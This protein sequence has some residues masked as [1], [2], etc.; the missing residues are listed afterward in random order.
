ML[1][2]KKNLQFTN[3][4]LMNLDSVL[5]NFD[6]R[7]VLDRPELR[8]EITPEAVLD[9]LIA[10]NQQF[11]EIHSKQIQ[12]NNSVRLSGAAKGHTPFAAVLNYARLSTSIEDVFDRKFGELY[13]INSPGQTITRP[14]ISAIE[15]GIL[16]M[17]IKVILILDNAPKRDRQPDPV[18][19]RQHFK[20][21]IE[22]NKILVSKSAPD[23]AE[24]SQTQS[25]SQLQ[26]RDPHA[27]ILYS[28][29][30]L[31]TSPLVCQFL[32]TGSLKIVG[33]VYDLDTGLVTIDS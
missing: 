6:E 12:R 20:L 30:R 5:G 27:N 25:E 2:V 16:M 18:P 11:V 14:E 26:D 13:T 15:Y 28:I 19:S 3:P 7:N 23:R 31:Q 22:N 10:G 9:R 32:K 33:G 21:E 24:L 17:G 29:D 4:S 1:T 8:A